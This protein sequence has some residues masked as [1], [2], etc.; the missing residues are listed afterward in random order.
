MQLQV[1]SVLAFRGFSDGLYAP[2]A[3]RNGMFTTGNLPGLGYDWGDEIG[4]NDVRKTHGLPEKK[5]VDIPWDDSAGRYSVFNGINAD[6]VD[7]DLTVSTAADQQVQSSGRL[8]KEW[9]AGN[10]H[11]FHFVQNAPGLYPPVAMASARYARWTDTVRLED[12]R[13]IGLEI[14]Y[15]PAHSANLD[16]Y[17]AALKEGLRY[18][19][20]AFGPYPYERLCLVESPAYGRAALATPGVIYL[21]EHNTWVSDL[22]SRDVFNVACYAVAL[23]LARQWWGY[24]VA[25]NHTLASSII[26]S[27]VARYAAFALLAHRPDSSQVKPALMFAGWDYG[28]GHRTDFDGERALLNANKGYEWDTRAALELFT[29]AQAIGTDS[30]N[31]ALRAFRQQWGLRNGG[32]YAGAHDL[33]AA[34]GMYVPDALR[35]W[36]A[37]EW[38]KRPDGPPRMP[39]TVGLRAARK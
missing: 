28:W 9:M 22:R 5:E 4:N 31:A 34:L 2:N 3:L 29:L 8:D 30:V 15:H 6:L 17:Q 21:A 24:T 32:P 11:Y 35:G 19:S 27:G 14:D 18:F 23:Q 10:R 36:F 16:R 20:H 38:E 12:G 13:T 37:D 39:G 1:H 26:N 33:Y 7:Y 25:P